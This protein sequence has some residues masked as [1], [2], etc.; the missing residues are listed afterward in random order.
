M[1]MLFS[2]LNVTL[3]MLYTNTVFQLVWYF[4]TLSYYS[5][6]L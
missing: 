5:K 1:L 4:L 2:R 6:C 3:K